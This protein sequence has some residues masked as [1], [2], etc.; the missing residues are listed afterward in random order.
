MKL[1]YKKG[2]CRKEKDKILYGVIF[3]AKVIKTSCFFNLRYSFK[4]DSKK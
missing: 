4:G 2:I 1:L 3:G